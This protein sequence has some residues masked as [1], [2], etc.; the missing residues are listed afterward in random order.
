[1]QIRKIKKISAKPT[2]KINKKWLPFNA[3]CSHMIKL[4]DH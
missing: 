1:M 2:K 4:M 3:N